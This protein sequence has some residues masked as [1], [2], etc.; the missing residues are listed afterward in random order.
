LEHSWFQDNQIVK[1]LTSKVVIEAS[2]VQQCSSNIKSN[3]TKQMRQSSKRKNPDFRQVVLNFSA[4]LYFD[5]S[6]QD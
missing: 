4:R 3:V 5:N 6:A 1:K 2:V